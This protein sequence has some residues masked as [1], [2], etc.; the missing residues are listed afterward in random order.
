MNIG[1]S[2]LKICHV[3]SSLNVGGA[4][5]IALRLAREQ[6]KDHDVSLFALRGGPFELEAAKLGLRTRVCTGPPWR[7]ALQCTAEFLR[8]RY[9]LINSHNRWA[10][11]YAVLARPSPV[12]M[13][14]HAEC[15][16]DYGWAVRKPWID[17][18]IAVSDRAAE[19]FRIIHPS[20]QSRYPL[21]V[22]K[23]GIALDCMALGR[24]V[25]RDTLGITDCHVLITVARLDPAKNLNLL[26][27]ALA[28]CNAEQRGI[29]LLL[30]GDGECRNKLQKLAS[31]LRLDNVVS[32]L[33]LR[34]DIA[35][36][37][38]ASD[39]FVLSS[40]T[41]GLPVSVLEAMVAGLPVIA[42]A[43]GG[44]PEVVENG[45]TGILVTPDCVD[46]LASAI[47]QLVMNP[48]RG[49]TMGEAGR[50]RV[51]S[52]F[53]LTTMAQEYMSFYQR[54]LSSKGKS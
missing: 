46:E 10:Q 12:I 37:L 30:V 47:A 34:T 23:N 41:E 18:I 25:T 6:A 9:D 54:I 22:V 48:E 3:L 24:D 51:A 45:T 13:T 15:R 35:N 38:A 52:H 32:F 29:R 5:R 1:S 7:I 49:R 39:T 43:V 50:Q 17:G 26:L 11:R 8:G 40:Q 14:L 20:F 36:L 53:S 42:T 31:D 27:H 16:A 2:R 28:L 21:V 19:T 33:G 44:V 4:E